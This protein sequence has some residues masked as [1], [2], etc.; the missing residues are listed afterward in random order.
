VGEK[1]KTHDENVQASFRSS[2]SIVVLTTN[3]MK[4]SKQPEEG[5]MEEADRR[6]TYDQY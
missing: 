5:R 1:A 6:E 4:S 3:Y 2:M